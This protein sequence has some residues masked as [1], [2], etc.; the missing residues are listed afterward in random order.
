[1]QHTLYPPHTAQELKEKCHPLGSFE[2]MERL[3]VAANMSELY[4]L[5]LRDTPL[6]PYFSASLTS[7]DLDEMNLEILRNTLYKAYLDDFAKFCSECGGAT[8]DIMGEMMHFEVAALPHMLCMLL[9]IVLVVVLV[10]LAQTVVCQFVPAACCSGWMVVL[11]LFDLHARCHPLHTSSQSCDK[12]R[13]LATTLGCSLQPLP[14][15]LCMHAGSAWHHALFSAP[16]LAAVDPPHNITSWQ[17]VQADRR[18]LNIT[19]NSIGTEVTRDERRKLYSDF[20]LLH[21]HGH[22]ELALAEDFD[23]IR[24]AM[25]KVPAYTQVRLPSTVCCHLSRH[26]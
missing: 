6:G 10:I 20:G 18:A 26:V 2:N 16:I 22:M 24:A 4:D 12:T 1:M 11:T 19:L 13:S 25:E 14:T 9:V 3:A 15:H 17:S 23:Q 21:P 8:A 7:E 5:V